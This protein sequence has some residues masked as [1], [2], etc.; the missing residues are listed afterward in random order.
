MISNTFF[1]LSNINDR[2]KMIYGPKYG[3]TVRSVQN[4]GTRV[5]VSLGL[6]KPDEEEF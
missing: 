5:T 4:V 3:V 2:V 1:G 6:Q